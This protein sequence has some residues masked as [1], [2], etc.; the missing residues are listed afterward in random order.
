MSFYW[1]R[2]Q[3]NQQHFQVYWVPGSKNIG[4][5]HTKHHQAA[6]HCAVRNIYLHRKEKKTQDRGIQKGCVNTEGPRT[7]HAYIFLTKALNRTGP[8]TCSLY[9]NMPENVFEY[10]PRITTQTQ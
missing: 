3:D 9:V 2:N 8:Q 1:L 10:V 6:R 4:D 5:Y 7:S